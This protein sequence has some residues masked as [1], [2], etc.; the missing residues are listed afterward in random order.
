[1]RSEKSKKMIF[2]SSLRKRSR[3]LRRKILLW[4]RKPRKRHKRRKNLKKKVQMKKSN[5]RNQRR[6]KRRRRRKSRRRKSQ[7]LRKRL[8]SKKRRKKN[9]RFLLKQKIKKLS[10][11][12]VSLLKLK[13]LSNLPS[14]ISRS[15]RPLLRP[16]IKR[17]Q[18]FKS[19]Q[20]NP[21]LT[22]KRKPR[23]LRRLRKIMSRSSLSTTLKLRSFSRTRILSNL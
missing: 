20:R 2:C 15:K 9:Q 1:M 22:S 3:V 17:L 16:L 14:L 12:R 19:N 5:Q 4:R 11:L 6:K 7:L 21:L 18:N 13:H 8:Q 10:S 23:N